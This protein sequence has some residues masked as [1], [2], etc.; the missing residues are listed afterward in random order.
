MEYKA[1]PTVSK[2]TNHG[3]AVLHWCEP[4]KVSLIQKKQSKSRAWRSAIGWPLGRAC[5]AAQL[6]MLGR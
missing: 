2:S 3:S 5:L 1:L 4:R 6:M